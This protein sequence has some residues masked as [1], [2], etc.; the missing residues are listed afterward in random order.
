VSLRLRHGGRDVGNP[1]VVPGF[2]P[3]N[4]PQSVRDGTIPHAVTIPTGTFTTVNPGDNVATKITTAGV[5]GKLWFTKGTYTS[6][7]A[8]YA[9]LSGQQWYLESA[10]GYTRSATDSVVFNGNAQTPAIIQSGTATG[11]Q[12]RGGVFTNHGNATSEAFRA[13]IQHTNGAAAAGADWL[14]EDVIIHTNVVRGI[15]PNGPGD[16]LRRCYIHSNGRYGIGCGTTAAV[17][18]G[19]TE[20]CR[21]TNNN[22]NQVD[23]TFDA[24]G[25][26]WTNFHDYAVQYCWFDNNY[27]SGC[28]FDGSNYNILIQENVMDTNRHWGVFYEISGGGTTIKRN[29]LNGNGFGGG[30]SIFNEPQIL[31][32]T[33]DGQSLAGSFPSIEV[34]QNQL[35][36][37]TMAIYLIDTAGHITGGYP[38]TRSVHVHD[39]DVTFTTTANNRVG[40]G[41]NTTSDQI[42]SRD[43]TFEDNHY[44]SLNVALEY[45]NWTGTTPGIG[46]TKNWTEWKAYGHDQPGGTLD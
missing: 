16:I 14:F 31:V 7:G 22:T 12:I 39:N 29:Y 45:W 5:N 36:G 33:C 24:G 23:T 35:I 9:P 37:S 3:T 17:S 25:T 40:A 26:K 21:I 2:G 1:P 11:V 20:Y 42:F 13:A 34:Q 44:H 27:G 46:A 19:S 6:T 15:V 4:G 32:S 8:S 18:G 30:N 43:N 10:A 41:G 28:W 38:A